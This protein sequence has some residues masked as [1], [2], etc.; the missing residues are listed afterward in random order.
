[1]IALCFFVHAK[2]LIIRFFF[3]KIPKKRCFRAFIATTYIKL[4]DA[5]VSERNMV[6]TWAQ[7]GYVAPGA[8]RAGET[9]STTNFTY[10][11]SDPKSSGALTKGASSLGTTWGVYNTVALNECEVQTAGNNADGG[12]WSIEIFN[13]STGNSVSYNAQITKN[14]NCDQL[15]PSFTLIGK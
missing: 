1:M 6:G 14:S 11:A 3:K 8:K 13:T 9:G 4:Q 7:V 10:V 2:N 5:Y 15:T 12:H